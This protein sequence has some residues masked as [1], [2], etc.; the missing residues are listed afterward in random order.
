MALQN[1]IYSKAELAKI[2]A[3]NPF[4]RLRNKFNAIVPVCLLRPFANTRIN[5]P[6]KFHN[7]VKS[8]VLCVRV[9]CRCWLGKYFPIGNS[10]GHNSLFISFV[11]EGR[12]VAVDDNRFIGR[13]FSVQLAEQQAGSRPSEPRRRRVRGESLPKTER[14]SAFAQLKLVLGSV[15]FGNQWNSIGRCCS[16]GPLLSMSISLD[17]GLSKNNAW[18]TLKSSTSRFAHKINQGVL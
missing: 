5:S 8:G 4:F 6:F 3:I 7:N 1:C 10:C 2:E 9:Q 14:F 13:L 12:I 16:C 15:C 11:E 17:Q 18:W